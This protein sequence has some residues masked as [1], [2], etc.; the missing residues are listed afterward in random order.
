MMIFSRLNSLKLNLTYLYTYF[1][2]DYALNIF[3]Y[4][5]LKYLIF[6]VK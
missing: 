4:D 6:F 2:N 3:L 5:D 1:S